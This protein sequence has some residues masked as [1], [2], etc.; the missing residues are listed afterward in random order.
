VARWPTHQCAPKRRWSITDHVGQQLGNY[1]LTR[2]LGH[3]GF[4]EVYL[5]EHLHLGTQAAIK[6]LN[7]QLADDELARFRDEAR[8]IARLQHPHIVRVLDFGIDSGLPFF[9][10]DYAP[11]GTLRQRYPGKIPLPATSIL[12]HVKQVALALQ[13]AHEQKVIHRDIKPEN[14]LLGRHD[15]VLLSDFGI[16]VVLQSSRSESIQETAGTVAY[17][18]PEQIQAQPGPASDQYALGVVVY[19]W[20]C[21]ERPFS[22]PFPEIAIKHTLVTPPSL[23]EKVPAISSGV[24]LVVLKALA[25]DPL[26]RF[27]SVEAFAQALAE[28]CGSDS[29]G[30]TFFI[31]TSGYLVSAGHIPTHNL[32]AQLTPLVGRN[33]EIAAVR[34][35]LR[36]P[37]VRLLTLTGTGGVGK[38]RL[39][40]QVATELIGDGID[41]VRFVPL[42][43]ISEPELVIPT[44]AQVL[45]IKEIAERP[46][47]EL[48]KASLLDKRL[49]LL[50]DNFEQVITAAPQV[51]E[52][53]AACPHLK[54]LS[55]SRAVLH[56]RG[57]HEFPVPPLALPNRK[58]L[59]DVE[60]LS[61]YSAVTLFLECARAAVPDFQ[62]TTDNAQAIAEI[63]AH[64]DG[65]PLAIELAAARIKVLPP[66]LLLTRL[67]YRLPV[68]TS[69]AQ[70][71]PARQQTLR[72]AI[73]WS[74]HLLD[75]REQQLFRR[76]CIF[77]AG[78]TLDAA[79][80]LCATLGNG[81]SALSVLDGVASLIDK[82]LLQQTE[83]GAGGP[84]LVMLETIREYG[85]EC[86]EAQ[87]EMEVTRR[88]HAAYYLR[89]SEEAEQEFGGPKQATGLERL[90]REHDNLRAA[91][92]W[93]LEQ[94]GYEEGVQRRELA[95]RLGAALQR[96]W[97]IRGHVSEGRTFLA[98]AL[99][100][101]EGVAAAIR[102]KALIAA[103]RLAFA[104][105][106]YHDG[107]GLAQGS[108]ALCKE[109]E[110]TSGIAFSL[111]LLGIVAWRK[112]NAILARERSEESLALFRA[113]GDKERI[114]YALFQLAYMASTQGEYA[115][116]SALLEEA[117][118]LH[119][120]VGN[121]RGIAHALWQ[122]AQ[123]LF[124][125]QADL[126]AVR[127]PLEE[128]LELSREIGFKEG[129]AASFC[130]SGQ[131]ALSQ[132][133]TTT[134]QA[135]AEQ[136]LALY[137]EIGHRHGTAE[138]LALLGQVVAIQG[139]HA[140]AR[141]LYEE[142]LALGSEVGDRLHVASCLEGL[143]GA[144]A[145]NGEPVWAAHLWGAAESLRTTIGAPLPPIERAGYELA[146]AGARAQL[147]KRDFATAWDEGR[148]MTPQ[149]AL[150]AHR[151]TRL[152]SQS[153]TKPLSPPPTKPLPTYPDGLTAREFEVLRLVAQGLTD[154]QIA[155]Q[156]VISPRTVNNH[157]TSI[158]SK[159]QVSSR[160][161]AT[162]YAMEHHLV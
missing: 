114:A 150:A 88:A 8:I 66:P 145:T 143:A 29:S 84:R 22:G 154:I 19:E 20:L 122:L 161:A 44:I 135:L 58:Q 78:F 127:V 134:A 40:L 33:H 85:L 62:M 144:V 4:A 148:S 128:S 94:A 11:N 112:G 52:L 16:A 82:S 91:Q 31:P 75:D 98:R 96:F 65:L 42:A 149:Q 116:G 70:D 7:V 43:S 93:S 138:A 86:L 23:R 117:V 67:E 95:L 118:A 80:A 21:G 74:Y 121:K 152:F 101:D 89:L 90:E 3:G 110:D 76:L 108:L 59:P 39:A 77:V 107:E 104:Q 140:A 97:M 109:L 87:G 63:C 153:P 79:E 51:A 136:S 81:D 17:M 14:M 105:G 158:Y 50:L 48:L 27:A 34:T 83:Q 56:I 119:R 139:N 106:D 111:Y 103:A 155:E 71:V 24:E 5:G 147:G 137:R 68:L 159:I 12:P 160:S 37:E 53:V 133:D 141:S 45:G 157:L 9:V 151:Q 61:Q 41:A 60:D 32:P 125:S 162:R 131:V 115:R 129:I 72:N 120:E 132:G 36:R 35:L 18:A 124:V 130:L 142:S 25:K 100:R 99:E 126:A 146:V 10:M 156:L 113:V 47:L 13:Y 92:Q 57:E 46:L 69:T 28:A 30:P 26:L 15:E 55:T 54:I 6:V 2:L 102:A 38:T 123:V 64:L 49:L 1:R 73:A